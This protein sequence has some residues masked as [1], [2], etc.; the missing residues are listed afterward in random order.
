MQKEPRE[1]QGLWGNQ[2]LQDFLANQASKVKMENLGQED[3]RDP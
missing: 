2:V 3:H 1:I